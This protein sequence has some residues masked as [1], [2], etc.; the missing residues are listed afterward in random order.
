[1]RAA[2]DPMSAL[3][4]TLLTYSARSAIMISE[5]FI[6]RVHAR[7]V[8]DFRV[9]AKSDSRVTFSAAVDH[10]LENITLRSRYERMERRTTL[11]QTNI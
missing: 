8:T 7:S 5:K 9:S 2:L 1:M 4:R 6:P 11:L 3:A 10:F